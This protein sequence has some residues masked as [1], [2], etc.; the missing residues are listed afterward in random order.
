M[1]ESFFP[2]VPVIAGTAERRVFIV[3]WVV[4]FVVGNHTSAPVTPDII[5]VE[6]FLTERAA[7]VP[8]IV[9]CPD[10]LVA[11]GTDPGLVLQ[12]AWA[13]PLSGESRQGD[14]VTE[15]PTQL[16]GSLFAHDI[17]LLWYS[18]ER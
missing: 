14:G 16:A 6:A 10:A 8:E 12:T 7:G 5:A 4:D 2:L 15:G 3:A 18:G 17:F 9:I 11:V 1:D 13:E